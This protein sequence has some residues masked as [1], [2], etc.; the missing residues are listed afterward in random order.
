V[1]PGQAVHVGDRLDTDAVGARDA[2]L[3]GVWLDR[4]GCGMLPQGAGI[5]V[6]RQ[7]AD[8]PAL[9]IGRGR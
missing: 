2:G 3:H 7:L 8:L 6:I 9:V 1:H 4:S 5:S